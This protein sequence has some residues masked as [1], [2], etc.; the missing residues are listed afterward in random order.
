MICI[1]PPILTLAIG[2]DM[3]ECPRS[4]RY[5]SLSTHKAVIYYGTIT[6][7]LAAVVVIVVSL[8]VLYVLKR[9]SNQVLPLNLPNV[10]HP[11]R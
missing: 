9:I 2:A 8:Y 6:K 11:K 1:L 10:Q 3:F 5:S 4:M 7:C